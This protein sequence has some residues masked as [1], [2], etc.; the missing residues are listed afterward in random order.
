MDASGRSVKAQFKLADREGAAFC[1]ILG[2]TE[3]QNRQVVLK[4]LKTTE[5]TTVSRDE[6]VQQLS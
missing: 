3:L 2:E 5:Q 4:D 1:I 6:I